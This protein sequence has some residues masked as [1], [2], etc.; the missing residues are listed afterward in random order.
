[1]SFPLLICTNCEKEKDDDDFLLF[2][3]KSEKGINKANFLDSNIMSNSDNNNST[4]NYLE[5]IEYP[6][7]SKN[8]KVEDN[9]DIS[10]QVYQP[11]KTEV[12]KAKKRIIDYDDDLIDIKPP[13]LFTE[14]YKN[15]TDEI[16]Y[17]KT[18]PEKKIESNL[19]IENNN[20]IR[21]DSNNHI[22]MKSNNSESLINN[23]NSIMNN[24]ILLKNYYLNF[25]NNHEQ[26]DNLE[27]I[28]MAQKKSEENNICAKNNLVNSHISNK[29]IG[30]QIDYPC[31]D[32]NNFY[33]NSNEKSSLKTKNIEGESNQKSSNFR[34]DG[35]AQKNFT[36]K[37]L[38][39]KGESKKYIKNYFSKFDFIK[40]KN[41]AKSN[42]N[43]NIDIIKVN[44]DK[45]NKNLNKKENDDFKNRL[46]KKKKKLTFNSLGNFSNR[47]NLNFKNSNDDFSTLFKQTEIIR[48]RKSNNILLQNILSK[49]INT[50][51]R[52]RENFFK[53]LFQTRKKE[54]K[55][56]NITRL[57]NQ[58]TILS[59][60]TYTNPF[61][62]TYKHKENKF[63]K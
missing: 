2:G 17:I 43:F 18:E 29:I 9:N 26:Q 48:F 49:N 10:N 56:S 23:D 27:K 45:K 63:K 30:E 40:P 4:N 24:K 3:L 59:S 8:N 14:T 38:Q 13:K 53:A 1:M 62:K 16:Q 15:K 39:K 35:L 25:Q 44:F 58:T 34:E 33:L 36:L 32:S 19:N 12:V 57:A 41:K 20:N 54:N 37:K 6:Y 11:I 55:F 22:K 7:S 50:I 28:K 60:K 31:P 47:F 5:I 52:T 51:N 21:N 42:N 46:I 61:I